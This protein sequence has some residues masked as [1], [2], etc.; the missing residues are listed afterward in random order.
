MAGIGINVNEWP[1][2]RWCVFAELSKD[3]DFIHA[4]Q[5][6]LERTRSRG[7]RLWIPLKDKIISFVAIAARRPQ[8]AALHIYTLWL[9]G[10]VVIC[11]AHTLASEAT[12]SDADWLIPVGEGTKDGHQQSGQCLW[13]GFC[14]VNPCVWYVSGSTMRRHC[15]LSTVVKK[16]SQY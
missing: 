6:P 9:P 3:A 7:I 12:V 15:T 11:A 16:S 14:A 10:V 1:W 2:V 8:D 4:K 5:K 13:S